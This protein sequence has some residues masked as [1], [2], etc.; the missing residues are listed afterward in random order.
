LIHEFE[1]MAQSINYCRTI[2]NNYLDTLILVEASAGYSQF[3]KIELNKQLELSQSIPVIVDSIIKPSSHCL[4]EVERTL[5]VDKHN[6]KPKRPKK[7]GRKVDHF[8]L[9]MGI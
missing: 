3:K 5:P 7:D 6:A 4:I 8:S 2:V 1:L 9:L